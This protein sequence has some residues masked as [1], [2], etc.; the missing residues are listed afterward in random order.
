VDILLSTATDLGAPGVDSV[1]GRG[2]LNIQAALSPVGGI[3]APTGGSSSGSSVSVVPI[4]LLL[5]VAGYAVLNRSKNAPKTLV[6]DQYER[7]YTVDLTNAATIRDDTPGLASLMNGFRYQN[8]WLELPVGN[9][10]RIALY[11]V[12]DT[13]TPSVASDADYFT[14]REE[15][16]SRRPELALSLHGQV[17]VRTDY[18]LDINQD[19]RRA[20]GA[21]GIQSTNAPV[22]FLSQRSMTAPYMGFSDRADSVQLGYRMNDRTQ[23]RMGV[24]SMHENG[25][26]GLQSNAAV[27]EGS[28]QASDK[29]E[30]S[31]QFGQLAEQGSLFGGANGGVFGVD[32]SQTTAIGVSGRY[33][34]TPNLALFGS[35]TEG[36]TRVADRPN[37]LVHNF[38]T[39]RSRAWGLGMSADNLVQRG[40]RLG[41][42]VSRPLR[43]TGGNVDLTLPLE[44]DYYGNITS[45]TER[46]SLVPDGNELDLEASY[47]WRVG[48]DTHLA[49]YLLYQKEPQHLIDANDRMTLL[50]IIQRQF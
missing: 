25:E 31:M 23:L 34:V 10:S 47:Q 41:F 49:T 18:R 32:N 3:S 33:R 15:T 2:L 9:N 1:Y 42:A 46:L 44:R 36:Y 30:L 26:F 28:Y 12:A 40:D 5:G 4:A 11:T 16:E 45:A 29:L 8:A 24:A 6:L 20:Y 43:A 35:Y 19:P 22:Q 7:P 39:V 13:A 38:S 14:L 21:L 17:G 27:I 37:S 50:G 48:R